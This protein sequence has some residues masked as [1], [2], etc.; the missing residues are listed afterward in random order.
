MSLYI[1]LLL[2]LSVWVYHF[3]FDLCTCVCVSSYLHTPIEMTRAPRDED[4]GRNV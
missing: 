1:F 4:A 3:P 2:L